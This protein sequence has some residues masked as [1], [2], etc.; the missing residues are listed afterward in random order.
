MSHF[1]TAAQFGNTTDG[2]QG[3]LLFFD[4]IIDFSVKKGATLKSTGTGQGVTVP[5]IFLI[6][7]SNSQCRHDL[8]I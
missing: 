5:K 4:K 8:K 7:F 2:H 6:F 3:S 1:L